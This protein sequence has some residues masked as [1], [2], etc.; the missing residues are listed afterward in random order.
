MIEAPRQISAFLNMS[1]PK[2]FKK[3][4]K[5]VGKVAA[6]SKFIF[7][8]FYKCI[9]LFKNFNGRDNFELTPKCEEAFQKLK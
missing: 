4:Q 5:L 8:F 2:N 3:V 1:L 9:S 6:L 7:H